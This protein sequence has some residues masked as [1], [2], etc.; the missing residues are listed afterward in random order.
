MFEGELRKPGDRFYFQN[1]IVPS[2]ADGNFV[3]IGEDAIDF[4]ITLADMRDGV[5]TL[6]IKHVPPAQPKIRIPADWMRAP[7]ADTPNNWVQV[8]R[9]KT[10]YTASVGKETFDVELRIDLADGKIL[11]AKMDN[12]VIKITRDCTDV[13]LTQCDEARPDPTLRRIEMSLLKD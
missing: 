12:P 2:W 13:A 9:T 7:V 3:V 8:R 6:L 4:T 5:A 11:S 10:G 1:P